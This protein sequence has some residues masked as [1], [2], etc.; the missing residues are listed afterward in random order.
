MT[1]VAAEH[2]R[3][4]RRK[5]GYTILALLAVQALLIVVLGQRRTVPPTPVTFGLA[6]DMAR[7]AQLVA[8][9]PE[10]DPAAF[11]LPN[12]HG[13]SR[14]GWL[15]FDRPEFKPIEWSEPPQ[16]LA[17]ETGD[18]GDSLHAFILSNTIPPLLIADK[19]MPA[20]SGQEMP[21]AIAPLRAESDLVLEGEL[22]GW[23]P[24]QA[25]DLPS[26][27]HTDL[28]TNTVV[29]TVVDRSGRAV[30]AILLAGSGHPEADAFALQK[31]RTARFRSADR[32]RPASEYVSGAL[33]FRWHTLPPTN[34]PPAVSTALP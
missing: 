31:A 1:T 5:W 30:T 12:W 17:L 16:W 26:W 18:L 7:E 4:S 2:P 22:A 29:H 9:A 15:A 25:M 27:R 13:F 6:V 14:D 28:L 32:P 20:L 23:T 33:V 3:W 10:L 24:A 21:P 8:T 34:A 19:A 11:A